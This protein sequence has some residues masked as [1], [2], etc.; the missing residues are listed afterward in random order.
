MAIGK[1]GA[2]NAGS[3]RGADNRASV[4]RSSVN[5]LVKWRA[6]G[7]AQELLQAEDSVRV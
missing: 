6:H 2:A 7:G 3:A 5:G 4:T 1:A